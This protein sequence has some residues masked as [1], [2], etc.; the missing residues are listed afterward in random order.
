M[1]RLRKILLCNYLYY[2]FLLFVILFS[3]IRINAIHRSNYT[4]K[5]NKFIG[6]ITNI[7]IDGDL[8]QFTLKDKNNEMVKANYFFKNLKEKNKYQYFFK[9]G[10][11]IELKAKFIKITKTTTKNI[12]NYQ[13][14]A[15]RKNMFYNLEIN[16]IIKISDNNNFVY[17]FKNFI[18][19]YFN[20]FKNSKYL[21]LLLLGDKTYIDE[22]I[23]SSF[24]E[25]GISHLFAISGMHVGI[26]TSL[27]LNILNAFKIR[28]EKRYLIVSIFLFI[29][30]FLVGSSASIMRAFLFFVLISINK[31][32]Y[33]YIDNIYLFI[34]TFSITLLINPFYIY[35]VGFQYS[36]L[37]SFTLIL[38]SNILNKCN[39]YF[40]NLFF[41]SSISFFSSLPITLYHFNQINLL[42]IF[43]N[44]FFVPLVTLL[45][46]PLSII[47][48]ILPFLGFIYNFLILVLEKSSLFLS[49]IDTFKFI[50]GKINIS[51][52][53]IYY[54]LFFMF[55]K[56][57]KKIFL[58]IFF[59][60]LIFHYF[61]YSIFD[62]DY[63]VMLDIGQGDSFIMHSKNKTI[64]IDTGGKVVYTSKKWAKKSKSSIVSNITIPY[65]K[66]KGI[67]KIDFLVLT[68]GH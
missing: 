45:L 18:Y 68:H 1:I 65:L 12:F 28:E 14:Y 66:S 24:R 31:I 23:I 8:L 4:S 53:F 32:Y 21:K 36:F 2:I 41:T 29:Y 54:I 46:F 44:L 16:T 7:K 10:D 51:F 15:M 39:S 42:S 13:E 9:L 47:I 43:Y 22:E 34:L 30:L 63:L 60:I 67:K 27:I 35:D 50:F 59:L 48:L 5:S 57:Y 37:I 33:F 6:I 49:S 40:I 64:M 56:Y 62:S 20:N 25:N 58:I 61:F 19:D 11:K 38:S 17:F 3:I 26:I 52:Y 55:L